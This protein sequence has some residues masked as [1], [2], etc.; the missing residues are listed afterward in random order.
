MSQLAAEYNAINLSQG[1]PNFPVDE[2]LTNIV[3]KLAKENVHQYTPMSAIYHY[4][5]NSDT[6]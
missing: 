4:Y 5:Q 6:S 1:F 2:R 3:A